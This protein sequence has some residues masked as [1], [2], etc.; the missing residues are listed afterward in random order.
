MSYSA[1]SLITQAA[2]LALIIGQGQTLNTSENNAALPLL[3][4]IIENW[5]RQRLQIPSVLNTEVTLTPGQ[6]TYTVGPGGYFNIERPY[7]ILASSYR[8]GS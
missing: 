3:N 6:Q 4:N 5:S 7:R 8:A 2:K 1:Q